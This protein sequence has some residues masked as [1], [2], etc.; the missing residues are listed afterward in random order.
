MTRPTKPAARARPAAAYH[1]GDL[2]QAL[3]R[4]A[5]E[6]LGADGA[7]AVG[8]REIAR[9]A[10]VSHAAPYRH[11]ANRETLLADLAGRGFERLNQRFAALPAREDAER[12]FVAMARA[13][14]QFARDEPEAW[15]LMF[16]D[17]LDKHAYPELMRISGLAF[18]TLR[19]V[20][21]ALGVAAPATSETLAAWAMAHGVAALVLDHRI[22]VH[23]E[24]EVDP[25]ELVQRAAE[26]FLAGLRES[27]R[28]R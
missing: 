9:R 11:Y 18:E 1:H 13:Y 23:V 3:L 15:R 24:A 26:V 16:G 17:A 19:E 4:A 25:D 10:G 21:Q 22:D 27:R 7:A 12:R 2:R 6:L 14:V 28:T 8:M 20:M 5:E